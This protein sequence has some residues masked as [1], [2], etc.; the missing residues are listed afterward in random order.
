MP[1][2]TLEKERFNIEQEDIQLFLEEHAE[3]LIIDL[4]TQFPGL[5]YELQQI[6][7]LG[8]ESDRKKMPPNEILQKIQHLAKIVVTNISTL[9]DQTQMLEKLKNKLIYDQFVGH[10]KNTEFYINH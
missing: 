8:S 7:N 3:D 2:E 10:L 5:Q 4:D 6:P 9:G 1:H